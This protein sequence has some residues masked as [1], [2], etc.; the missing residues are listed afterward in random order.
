MIVPMCKTYI[1]A[2]S[3]DRRRLVDAIAGL[4]VVHLAPVDPSQAVPDEETVGRIQTLRRALQVLDAEKGDSPHLSEAPHGPFRQT[5]T[6]PFF[7]HADEAA[8][9]VLD[10]VRRR[11][12][13]EHGLTELYHQL[14]RLEMW[15][16]FE[17]R[18]IE[19][20]AAAGVDVQF[21][22]VP[23]GQVPAIRAECVE[24]VGQ[25]PG[26]KLLVALVARGKAPELPAE[27]ARLTLP[28]R[29]A[30]SIR[31]EAA[32]IDGLIK[33][34]R[35]RLG[36]LAGLAGRMRAELERLEQQSAETVALRGAT[37]NDHLFAIQ[38]WIPEE[39][40]SLLADDLAETGI[41][42]AVRVMK[43]AGN[44]EPPT[45]IRSPVWTRPI[46]G[47][48]S[49]MGTVAGYREFDVSV[50]FLIA[51]PI[52][53]AILI[54]DG[55][56]GAVL[57]S[58]LTLGYRPATRV[59]GSRFTQLLLVV[60]V[61]TLLWGVVC[62]TFFGVTLY[63]PLIP[64]DL[65]AQSRLLMMK[66]CFAMGA[67]HLSIAQLWQAI[68]MFPSWR[69]LNRVGWAIF[70]WGMFGVVQMF[71]LRTPL[72][73]DT[74]W[75]YFLLVGAVLAIF[76][77]R[78]SWNPVRMIALGVAAFPLSM[79]SAFSDVISYVRLMAVGLASSV[80][81]VS[82]NKLASE[83]EGWT[84]AVVILV[85][86]HSLN[87]GLA[88]IAMFA[89]GVRLNMLEFCNNLGMKWTGYPYSPYLNRTTR[90]NHHGNR[91]IEF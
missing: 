71:V 48:F 26:R 55:G 75:P 56:Y 88:M 89:H 52:F 60:G 10:I 50:P 65:S 37:A 66:I 21:Y 9:E 58:A 28:P 82:F 79:I 30:Q 2:R 77:L 76:F 34:D 42:A 84:L 5:G 69:L 67:L 72:G 46:E 54:S 45:W 16:D 14:R 31:A 25:L 24:L 1:T 27:A 73:W 29:D 74:P 13:Q 8:Q 33:S 40:A 22:S 7:P 4:G 39:K 12:S 19:R 18:E 53:T 41:P 85:L 17:L 90:S 87:M 36:E 44:E 3:S 83:A 51:L 80:L 15:G 23:A 49:I 38:G 43:A 32:E 78:P 47:L 81:A 70:V 63:P 6:V 64:V 35:S 68:R 20:L 61:V 57:L 59:L 91:A 11:A 86:G 62:A